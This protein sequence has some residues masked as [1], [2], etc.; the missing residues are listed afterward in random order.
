MEA[1]RLTSL[2]A[3]RASMAQVWQVA[4]LAQRRELL[5]EVLRGIRV[6]LATREAWLQP[7][8]AYEPLFAARRR[9]A[10]YAREDSN[11]RPLGPQPNTLSPEL[12][13]LRVG[14]EGE[15]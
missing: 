8:E 3:R 13:A 9:F 4:T 12:R 15:I 6:D 10:W 1:D 11:L 14:A 2:G 5:R 7:H